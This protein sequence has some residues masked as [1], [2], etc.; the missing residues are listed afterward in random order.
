MNA[1]P[2]AAATECTACGGGLL[3]LGTVP[4]RVGGVGSGWHFFREWQE[5][6]EDLFPM[7]V[8]F[9][10]DCR[11]IDMRVPPGMGPKA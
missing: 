11:R 8:L 2:D 9:C 6:G 4:F 1:K 10:Q 7:E 3:T 5:M